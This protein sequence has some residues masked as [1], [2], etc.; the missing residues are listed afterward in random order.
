MSIGTVSRVMNHAPNVDPDLRRHVLLT[1]RALGFV[2]RRAQRCLAI[3]T[4]R[5]SPALPIGYVSVLTTLLWRML[6]ERDYVVELI[7]VEHLDAAYH[8]HVE[9]IIG[10]VFD[11]R[12][13]RLCDIPN[14]PLLTINKPLTELGIHSVCANHFQQAYDATCH[15]LARGHREIGFLA[16][17]PEE[18]GSSQRRAGYL[19][20]LADVGLTAPEGAIRY[21]TQQPVYDI[22]TRW[23][24]RGFSAVLN[25]SEDVALEAL[26]I[27]ANVLKLRVGQQ[28]ATISLE[29]LPIYQ[30]L[31]PPQTTIRQPLEQLAQLAVTEMLDL[32]DQQ[33]QHRHTRKPARPTPVR[34]HLLASE[35]I[36]RDSVGPG[37]HAPLSPGEKGSSS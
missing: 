26:H 28:I 17:E 9:G 34:Q 15:L 10:V 27:L 33:R 12:F 6:A 3:V 16:I 29:D 22:L 14:L 13:A 20:A 7:D 31:S 18:W 25:L 35:L 32:C 4:G 37:P 24:D 1:G 30:H 8:A 11:P 19:Q 21:S 5:H 36:E 2:P 23:V